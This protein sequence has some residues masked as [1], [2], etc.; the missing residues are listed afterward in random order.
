MRK[1]KLKRRRKNAGNSFIMVIATVSFL[2]VLVAA[3]LVAIALCYRMRAIDLN[4]KDNFYYL[5]QAMDEIYAGV[6]NTVGYLKEAYENTVEVLVYYDTESKSYV[7]MSNDEANELM[8]MT[9]MKLLKE[10]ENYSD[11]TKLQTRLESFVSNLKSNTNPEGVSVEFAN[12]AFDT[13]KKTYTIKNLVLTRTA[14]YSTYNANKNGNLAG[15]KEFT[16]TLETDLVVGDPDLEVNFNGISSDMSALYGFAC[17]ADRGIVVDG[18]KLDDSTRASGL[19]K[20]ANFQGNFYAGADFYNKTEATKIASDDYYGNGA[21][22]QSCNGQN[23]KSMYSG[24]Y[25]DGANAIFSSDLLVVPGTISAMNGANL[26]IRSIGQASN[27]YAEVWADGIVL[28]GY[29]LKNTNDSLSGSEI[30]MRAKAFIYDDLEL[31]ANASKFALAGEYYGYSY[32]SVDNRIFTDN[33]AKSI[34]KSDADGSSVK[35]QAHYNSSAIILNGQDTSLDLA[36]TDALYIAGQSYIE[37]SKNVTKTEGTDKDYEIKTYDFNYDS[38]S[39]K[40]YTQTNNYDVAGN[41]VNAKKDVIQDYKTGESISIKSNQLAYIPKAMIRDNGDR[42]CYVELPSYFNDPDSEVGQFYKG[43]WDELSKI[44]LVKT[45]ISGKKYYFFDFSAMKDDSKRIDQFIQDYSRLFQQDELTED[46]A[47]NDLTDITDYEHFSVKMLSVS[48]D[49]EV[50]NALYD[51]Q[52]GL[53]VG[54]SNIYSRGAITSFDKTS[55]SK[56]T[57]VDSQNA[58]FTYKVTAR[59]SSVNAL[60]SA[61]NYLKNANN[62][63]DAT[64]TDQSE[65]GLDNKSQS[66]SKEFERQ[67]KQ[68]KYMLTNQSADTNGIQVAEIAG[69]TQGQG[70]KISLKGEVVEDA[71]SNITLAELTP[72]NYYFNFDLLKDKK[73]TTKSGYNIW[74]SEK[75]LTIDGDTV[76]RKLKGIILSKGDVILENVD[77]FSGLIVS[78]GKV[79]V[80]I[81]NTTTI[82]NNEVIVKTILRECDESRSASGNDD[83]SI[84]CDIFKKYVSKYTPKQDE[85]VPTESLNSINTIG[86]DDIISFENWKKNVE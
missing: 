46:Q 61:A 66:I 48:T 43:F 53:L 59:S 71:N 41:I 78:G 76:G 7:T 47:L 15:P 16:Q 62:S 80:G 44:P 75:T 20:K 73:Y 63:F 82:V 6:G 10:D 51:E 28:D 72:I 45:E 77:E 3:I 30:N 25:I 13:N 18:G 54:Y 31:N 4:S 22:A 55:L 8:S 40:V 50:N 1:L 38:Q 24:I 34:S 57:D 14:K 79:Y 19:G 12:A 81:D 69:T 60:L 11:M 67:Y 27:E 65:Q 39:Q 86:I 21:K 42:G 70:K 58:D 74:T 5:E 84:I 36:Y 68:F 2:S 17:I 49:E 9:F 29:A 37:L 85:T 35:G 32:G 83:M 56:E 33:V 64:V 23:I 52:S 26:S